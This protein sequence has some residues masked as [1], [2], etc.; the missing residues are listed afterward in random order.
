MKLLSMCV[1]VAAGAFLAG[2][3]VGVFIAERSA[4]R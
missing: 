4:S 2:F 3:I 1:A